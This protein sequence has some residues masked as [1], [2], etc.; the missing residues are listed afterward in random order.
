METVDVRYED[1]QERT[2]CKWCIA[3]TAKISSVQNNY[4]LPISLLRLNTKLESAGY[5]PMKS[6]RRDLSDGVR[7]IKLMVSSWDPLHDWLSISNI[8]IW[9]RKLWVRSCIFSCS[10]PPI[11]R[12]SQ[13]IL[14]WDDTIGILGWRCKWPRMLIWHWAS[15]PPGALGSLTSVLK[16]LIYYLQAL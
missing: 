7:L 3:W 6:L 15:F 2:F 8:R 12:Y 14:P 10:S 1:V 9:H 11:Y 13:A 16:V 5:P 4:W